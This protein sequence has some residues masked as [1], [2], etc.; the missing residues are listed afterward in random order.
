M[1]LSTLTIGPIRASALATIVGLAALFSFPS[2]LHAQPAPADLR[3]GGSTVVRGGD[4]VEISMF[5]AA[6]ERLEEVSGTRTV[7][8]N[9]RIFLPYV[10]SLEVAGQDASEIRELLA[11]RY[12]DFYSSPV[13]D[14][15]TRIRVN[16]TGAV[17]QPGNYFLPPTSTLV[18]ALATAGGT[19]AEVEFTGLGA[20]A[21]LSAIRLVRDGRTQILD[22]RPESADTTA[23]H[24]LVHSGDWLH[25]P[26]RTESR[27]RSNLQ[28]LGSFFS[29]VGSVAALIVL[30][31]N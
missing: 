10:G 17:R 14:V 28:L 4:R 24:R 11:R 20:A 3:D 27:W 21:D 23:I 30:I 19:T 8:R 22:M 16:V 9:G 29:V 31:G 26:P 13:V 2:G 25:V 12:A 6:G 7:D 5:T 18:D 1:Q 15:E